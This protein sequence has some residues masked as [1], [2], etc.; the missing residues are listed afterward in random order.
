[1]RDLLLG[2]TRT[3]F[4]QRCPGIF[5][6]EETKKGSGAAAVLSVKHHPFRNEKMPLSY[7]EEVGRSWPQ[8]LLQ[9]R[10]R[11]LSRQLPNEIPVLDGTAKQGNVNAILLK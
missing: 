9:M 11:Y 8:N 1:M 7:P 6:I 10:Q 4:M 3:I 5:R 2:V